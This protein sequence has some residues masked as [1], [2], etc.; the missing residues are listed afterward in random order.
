M[1]RNL[2]IAWSRLGQTARA[3]ESFAEADARE[4]PKWTGQALREAGHLKQ[5]VQAY[6]Y[7]S[8]YFTTAE[9]WLT[10]A[11]VAWQAEDD[12]T[13]AEAFREAFVRSQGAA[14]DLASQNAYAGVLDNIGDYKMCEQIAAHL[15]DRAKGDATFTSCGMHHLAC[16]MLGQRRFD[17]AASWAEKAIGLNPLPENAGVFNDTLDRARTQRPRE[18]KP[19]QAS[20]PE[21][22]AWKLILDGD[23]HGAE[24]FCASA[25]GTWP[26]ARAR[27][28]A[29]RF[30]YESENTRW[31]AQAAVP[32]SDWLLGATAGQVDL[33]AALARIEALRVREDGALPSDM[34]TELGTRI[35]RE[36]F[37]MRF[38]DRA[39]KKGQAPVGPMKID[40]KQAMAQAQ[41]AQAAMAAG[42]GGDPDPVVFPGAK[43]AKL[44]DYVRIMKAMQSGNP[45]G[46]LQAVGLDMMSYGQVAAQ[47][48]QKLGQDAVLNAKFAQMMKQ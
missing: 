40:A 3:I 10:L 38:A 6:R 35:S 41:S 30:R 23:F 17:E 42:M 18:V 33:Q 48:G 11:L 19:L 22:R 13:S 27:L 12:E 29:S 7:A 31:V 20:A 47:W 8:I 36:E 43:V 25:P 4:A 14:I 37:Q 1:A 15:L 9:D 21:R 44:S 26:I 39:S 24:Q 46:A 28:A 32:V 34:P 16:A 2:G 45:M 5:A